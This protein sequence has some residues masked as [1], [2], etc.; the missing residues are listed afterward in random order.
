MIRIARYEDLDQI[1]NIIKE[2]IEDLTEQGNFQWSE[3]YPTENHMKE[4]I[5]KASLYIFEKNNEVAGFICLNKHEDIA[6]KPLPWRKKGEAIVIHRFAVKRCYQRQKIGTK[7]IEF[8]EN[9]ARNK[10][11]Y[12][13]KVDTNSKNI[14]MNALFKKMGFVFIGTIH[15]RNL[16]DPFNCYDKVLE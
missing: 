7:L 16:T 3:T 14:R 5:K 11:I 12:Y 15:L 4:D 9:F 2:T 6:Y 1:L 10:G 13:L 8:A